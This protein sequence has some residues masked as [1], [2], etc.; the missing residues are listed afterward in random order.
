MR[1][2]LPAAVCLLLL[3]GSARAQQG[4]L[5]GFLN[6]RRGGGG[7]LS[8][9][10]GFS[11]FPASNVAGQEADFGYNRSELSLQFRPPMEG[12]VSLSAGL[13]ASTFQYDTEAR[14][15]E[16]G[17]RHPPAQWRIRGSL[18]GTLTL[19]DED[20]FV[21]LSLGIGTAADH[22]FFSSR[23]LTLFT[24]AYLRL[25]Q[26]SSD[27]WILALFFGTSGAELTSIPIP[28]LAYFW[29]PSERFQALVGLPFL[30][31]SAN[32]VGQ[33]RFFFSYFPITNVNLG[34]IYR[35]GPLTFNAGWGIESNAFPPA[36]R[37]D[38]RER[39]THYRSR[40]RAGLSVPVF[41]H[42]LGEEK[43]NATDEPT[44]ADAAEGEKKKE[45]KRFMFASLSLEAGWCTHR[46]AFLGEGLQ[47]FEDDRFDISDGGF[48]S[49][50]LRFSF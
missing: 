46:F 12:P 4:E 29:K 32:P 28:V 2:T 5:M 7:V 15:P 20:S 38:L 43:E 11:W 34:A 37:D 10:A 45:G 33:L 16:S 18:G 26:G 1:S 36:D 23:E 35:L 49:V 8:G 9:K 25:P 14:F 40:V 6:P 3:A 41:F 21:G 31:V 30:F 13:D 27:A 44:D 47:D 17:V 22:P 39:V 48:V 19:G 42:R 24:L 50:S